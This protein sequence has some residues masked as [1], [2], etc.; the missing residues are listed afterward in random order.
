MLIL[1]DQYA[2]Y[3]EVEWPSGFRALDLKYGYP[4]FKSPTLPAAD[5]YLSFLCSIYTICLFIYRILD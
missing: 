3:V 2:I 4:L 1:Q 5:S